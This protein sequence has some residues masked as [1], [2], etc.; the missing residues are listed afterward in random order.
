[1]TDETEIN[2]RRAMMVQ[3]IIALNSAEPMTVENL[4]Q[5]FPPDF[6]LGE[7]DLEHYRQSRPITFEGEP[8]AT[9]AATQEAA[10]EAASEPE[11]PPPPATPDQI[12]A[13]TVRRIAADQ[14]LANARVAVITAGN[15]ERNARTK[16]AQAV[17]EFQNGF[18]KVTRDQLM[19]DMIASEQERKAAGHPSQRQGRPGN[20]EV[21]RSAFYGRGGNP[22]RHSPPPWS[23]NGKLVPAGTP[24]AVQG[25][26]GYQ[27]GAFR[28][29][30]KGAPNY[31]PRR[32]AVAAF[33][34][35]PSEG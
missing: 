30:D 10:P 27:R 7:D 13:A 34:K 26:K 29:Q 12:E 32:G 3:N 15:V 28:S 35:V 25:A 23:L 31:D 17:T 20:S 4:A 5:F 11:A 18:P 24:G 33:P 8:E 14:S 19:R 16:L 1:M 22:A 2:P 21:D 6:D 9:P